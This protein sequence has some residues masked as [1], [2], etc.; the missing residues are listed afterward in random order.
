MENGGG[1]EREKWRVEWRKRGNG[2]EWGNGEGRWNGE[3]WESLRPM[4]KV[5]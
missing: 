3:K 1:V 4:R 2:K 5:R